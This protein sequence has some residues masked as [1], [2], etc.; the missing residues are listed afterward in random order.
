[1][2]KDLRK[3]LSELMD[4]AYVVNT[5]TDHAVFVDFSGHIN[6]IE[7]R[8]CKNGWE[9]G[10]DFDIQISASLEGS[11]FYS[12][13]SAIESLDN[14]IHELET[15]LIEKNICPECTEQL[16][17]VEERVGNSGSLSQDTQTVGAVCPF[18]N[19]RT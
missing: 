18:C 10:K 8:V 14:I 4:I 2:N 7:I 11:Y 5:L 15:L 9:S 17:I 6:S 19:F 16:S 12:E 3:K 1:M 13:K